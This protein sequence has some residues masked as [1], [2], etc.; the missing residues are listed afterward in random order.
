MRPDPAQPTSPRTGETR[1]AGIVGRRDLPRPT[2]TAGAG[3]AVAAIQRDLEAAKAA[4]AAEVATLR[5][6]LLEARKQ[7]SIGELLGTTTH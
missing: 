7:A 2:R 3:P 5:S 6:E 1:P 4:H